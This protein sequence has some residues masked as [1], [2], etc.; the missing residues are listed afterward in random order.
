VIALTEDDFVQSPSDGWCMERPATPD[1]V[2]YPGRRVCT[3]GPSPA[4]DPWLLL[5]GEFAA[6]SDVEIPER[7]S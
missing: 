7:E 6:S 5:A 3:P 4:S 2:T 1:A